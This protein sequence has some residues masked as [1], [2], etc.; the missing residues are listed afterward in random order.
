MKTSAENPNR[1]LTI[2]NVRWKIKTSADDSK[3]Q[4]KI[5]NVEHQHDF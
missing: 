4:P 5:Q 3:R 2:Q 1:P